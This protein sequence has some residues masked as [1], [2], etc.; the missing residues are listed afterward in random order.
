MS[1][2]KN[3]PKDN[4]DRNRTSP[5]AFTGNKF[6][7]RMLGSSMNASFLNTVVNTALANV[8]NEI[9]D[10]LDKVKNRQEVRE[11]ALSLISDIYKEHKRVVFSGNG[12][13]KGLMKLIKED[14]IMFLLLLKLLNIL[15]IKKAFLYLKS[16]VFILLRKL[17]PEVKLCM[18]HMCI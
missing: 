15:M 14:L 7:F 17:K 12:Y 1:T 4:S 3:L 18:N 10:E 5:V 11:K 9:A 2:I 8:L 6:E 16:M 13:S